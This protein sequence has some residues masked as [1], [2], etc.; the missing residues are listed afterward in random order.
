MKIEDITNLIETRRSHFAKEFNGTIATNSLIESIIT[1]ANWAPSHKLTMPWHFIVFEGTSMLTLTNKI[2]EIQTS[3]NPEMEEAKISKIKNI[4]QNVSHSI[5][6]CLKPSFKV[7]LWEEYCSI[8][9]AVQNMYL[10]LN[11]QNDFG[12]Y[13]TTGNATNSQEMKDYLG[14]EETHEHLGFFFIGGLDQ[15]RT[16]AHRNAV[17]V[18]WK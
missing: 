15:K 4:P 7:P 10:T 5:A 18:E 8:G 12:G 13:W 9:A 2:L 14:L 6:S 17:S 11:T 3:K 1:N 16:F